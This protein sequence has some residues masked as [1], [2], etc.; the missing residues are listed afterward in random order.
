MEAKHKNSGRKSV[1]KQLRQG[2]GKWNT[3]DIYLVG[4]LE[5]QVETFASCGRLM[6]NEEGKGKK[7][8]ISGCSITRRESAI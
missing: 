4:G 7:V 8:E 2:S 6:K 1:A 5:E 3:R